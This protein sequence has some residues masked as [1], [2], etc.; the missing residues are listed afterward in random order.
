[1]K[2]VLEAVMVCLVLGIPVSLAMAQKSGD[3]KTPPKVVVPPRNDREKPP[4]NENR[5]K[6][7]NP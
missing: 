1:M 3:K 4:S 7:P 2:G 6:R 5:N